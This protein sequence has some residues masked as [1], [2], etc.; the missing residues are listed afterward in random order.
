MSPARCAPRTSSCPAAASTK[1]PRDLSV[2]TLGRLL[3]P[4]DFAD[5]VVA[6]RNGYAIKIRDIGEVIDGGEDPTSVSVLNGRP[7]VSLAIRKQSGVNTVALVDGIKRRMAEIQQTLPPTF[8]VRMIRDD[9][10]FIRA[11]LDAIEEHLVLGAIF[12]ALVVYL[13]PAELPLDDHRGAS[14]FRRRSSARSR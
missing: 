12:A 7:A 4:A 8:Q 3:R 14:R 10:E 2:R 13:F 1:A 9:S 6:T 11:S 5:L